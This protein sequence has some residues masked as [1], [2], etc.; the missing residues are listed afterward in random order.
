MTPDRR[1]IYLK[2]KTLAD[3]KI[4]LDQAASRFPPL[5]YETVDVTAAA[6]RVL[7]GPVFAAVSSPN[8]HA[9]AMDG[10]AVAAKA[11]F[12]ASE[13]APKTLI[14]GKDA[15]YIN[16]GHVM[17]KNTDAVI[18]IENVHV[19]GDSIEN[20]ML[21]ITAPV[22]PWQ[23]VRRIGE[24][25]VAT[26]LVFPRNHKITPYC[27]GA[28]ITAGI[29]RVD[30]YKKPAVFIQPTGSELVEHDK[31]GPDGLRPGQVLDANS[32]M[33]GRL[34]ETCG[35]T[36]YRNAVIEDDTAK[37]S[38]AIKKAADGNADMIFI[39]GGSS[40]GSADYTAAVIS[41]LGRVLVHGV[42]MMPGKPVIIGEINK[43]PVFGIP[44]YPVS[45]II[46]F[47]QL[48]RPLILGMLHQPHAPDQEIEVYPTRKIPSKLGLEEFL[49][50]KLGNVGGKIVATPLPRGAGCITSF[51]EADG[52]IRIPNHVEG[53]AENKPA[54]AALLRPLSDIRNTIVAVGSHDNTMDVLSDLIR[55]R[56]SRVSL[57]SSHVGSMGGLMAIKKGLAHVAGTHLLDPED[58][59]YNI[60]YIQKHLPDLPVK[61]VH[62]VE[63]EQGLIVARNNPKAIRG[64]EDLARDDIAFINRQG[65][66]GTRILLDFK[67]RQTG[68]NPADIAGYT[69]EEFTHMAVA[70][71]VLSGSADVGLGICAAA[72]A[73]D[74]DFIP[75]ITESYDLLMPADVFN[76]DI[77]GLLME[78]IA[79][80]TFK[81]RVRA[82]GGY[83]TDNTGK[84]L[85]SS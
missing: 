76:A 84:I 30:V 3:A 81:S 9:A 66:S 45:A 5:G 21:E 77:I 38:R 54:M 69:N 64:I 42:T 44:G 55:A 82:L 23:N 11:T 61:L 10:I 19:A 70:V 12:G 52:I 2:M 7:S 40:A 58:G 36:Y 4:I 50:V 79:S 56:S 24:D 59:S 6:G 18:M 35:G 65:G 34:V 48:I 8:Y 62:L 85:W 33:L 16:T 67:L 13:T 71:A 75:V 72:K 43:K 83:H 68:L 26:E 49:R 39:T 74:L 73:L 25:I 17:P 47:E 37:I 57:S 28:L 14:A 51:T 27:I 32:H 63:R 31:T 20:Q 29:C 80:D 15:Y 41:E 22:F 1:N 78:I 60:S 46:A 53:I